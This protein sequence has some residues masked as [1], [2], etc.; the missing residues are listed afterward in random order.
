MACLQTWE[1]SDNAFAAD[2]VHRFASDW[3]LQSR[4]RAFLQTLVYS[5]VRNRTLL[6]ALVK[7]LATGR[8]RP[9]S[10]RLLM[11]GL[12]EALFLDSPHHALVNEAVS[13]AGRD[14]PL[15][16]AVLRRVT[17]EKSEWEAH[18]AGLSPPLRWSIP[19]FLW[20]RWEHQ[21]GEANALALCRWNLQPAE[22]WF[23]LNDRHPDMPATAVEERLTLDPAQPGFARLR[24]DASLPLDWLET[25]LIYAQDPSTRG[26]VE[27]MELEP[28]QRVL[29]AC[30]APGGKSLAIGLAL[31]GRGTLVV[32]D[33]S[34]SRLENLRENLSRLG[35]SCE[36][37]LADW[38]DPG[39]LRRS[40]VAAFDRILL[41]VPCSNTGV[42]R[43]R[44]DVPYR[45]KRSS[46][47]G[48]AEL[49]RTLLAAMPPLLAPGGRIVY[50]TCSIDEEENQSLVDDFLAAQPGF[51]LAATRQ[52]LPF[53]D[54]VDGAFAAALIRTST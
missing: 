8:V 40:W 22:P 26:A 4:D 46:F 14:K 51:A 35:V 45:L 50:S 16:N 19:G 31:K 27:L 5:V 23:R 12:A 1:A 53:R 20:D 33:S 43:R 38:R 28:G 3:N 49:Q 17:R 32:T 21:L 13:R 9:P 2:L 52:T 29:D 41:D 36:V 18:I 30:A 25:G 47:T 42:I 54:H 10:R 44:I 11:L 48:H 34:P 15:V 39:A 24:D 6:Q 7:E 37:E